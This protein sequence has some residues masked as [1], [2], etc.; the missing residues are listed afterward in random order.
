M[1]FLQQESLAAKATVA[2]AITMLTGPAFAQEAGSSNRASGAPLANDV[3]GLA[4]IVVTAQRREQRLL[5]VPVAES[6]VSGASL[7]RNNIKSLSDLSDRLPEVKIASGLTSDLLNIRGVGSGANAGFE[8]SVGTFVDGVYRERSRSTRAALL[9]VEQVEVLKGP[10]STFFG[11]NVIAGALN[12]TTRK[13]GKE[14]AYDATAT[15]G[16]NDRDYDF[17][18]GITTP[19]S[20]VLSMRVAARASGMRGYVADDTNGFG[21]DNQTDQGRVSL[22]YEPN[23]S[24]RSDFRIDAGT[25]KTTNAY[26]FELIGCPAP[27]PLTTP[28]T[29]TCGRAIAYNNGNPVDDTLNY[30]TDAPPSFANYNFSEVEWTNAWQ[31]GGGTLASITSYFDHSF[32]SLIQQV[33]IQIVSP[34]VAGY[35][36]FPIEPGEIYHDFSQEVRFQSATG[37]KFEYMVGGYFA[38][39]GLNYKNPTGFFNSA[40]GANPAVIASGSGTTAASAIT[41]QQRFTEDDTTLSPFAAATIRPIDHFRINLGARFSSVHKSATRANPF[42]VSYNLEPGTYTP[43]PPATQAVL[44]TV[45]GTDLGPFAQPT[46]TDSKF[47]PSAGIQ[48]DLYQ[49]VMAYATY[50]KGFKAGGYNFASRAVAFAPESVDAYEVG[51]KGQ[52][53]DRRLVINADVFRSNYDNLQESVIVFNGISTYTIVGNA[54]KSRSQGVELGSSLQLAPNVALTGDIAYLD[55]KYLDYPDGACT[56]VGSG[57]GCKSQDMS[58][59]RR[60]YSPEYSGNVGLNINVPVGGYKLTVDPFVYFSSWFFESGSADPL[61]RQS[62]YAKVDLRIGYGPS[63]ERWQISV[64]GRNLSDKITSGYRQPMPGTTGSVI[65]IPDPPRIISLQFSIRG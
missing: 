45:I 59:Q 37:G 27:A 16:F 22:R 53:F 57:T 15:Y 33:P 24:F 47:L 48:Y 65:A 7:E 39:S 50:S 4:E 52:F 25:S 35:Y 19:L 46:R 60:A 29:S 13:P 8:Q 40:L 31:I 20:D 61:L 1:K 14:S 63:D 38:T 56:I 12:I 62:G 6:V 9:D 42:G 54:A 49:D 2:L 3:A 26:P 55:S 10:Q 21:P 5:D 32:S 44:A 17:E 41:A 58:G 34:I 11:D 36:G 51:L 43:L 30:H 23:S 18:G 28:A 64:I